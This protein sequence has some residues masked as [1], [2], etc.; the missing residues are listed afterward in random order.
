VDPIEEFV[1]NRKVIEFKLDNR[2]S[3]TPGRGEFNVPQVLG[4]TG[5]QYRFIKVTCA[6]FILPMWY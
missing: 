2:P 4:I 5:A 3:G 1:K 6:Y